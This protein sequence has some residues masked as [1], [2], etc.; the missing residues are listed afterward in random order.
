MVMGHW[1][2]RRVLQMI[3]A[4]WPGACITIVCVLCIDCFSRKHEIA[5]GSME[6][7]DRRAIGKNSL[8]YQSSLRI[9]GTDISELVRCILCYMED[10]WTR[11]GT[12]HRS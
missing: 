10:T 9:H 7:N 8:D 1:K 12:H 2:T 4:V 3:E 5:N 11:L 6:M